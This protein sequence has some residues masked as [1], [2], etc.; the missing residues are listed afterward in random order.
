MRIGPTP[1]NANVR[2]YFFRAA[3]LWLG[4]ARKRPNCPNEPLRGTGCLERSIGRVSG[5]EF[6]QAVAYA[7]TNHGPNQNIMSSERAGL[8]YDYS[9]PRDHDDR[10]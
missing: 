9:V 1:A 3:P 5:R 10:T 4:A 6:G 2:A 7:G 8:H